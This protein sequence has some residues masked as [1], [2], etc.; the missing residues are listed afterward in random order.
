MC[1]C[2]VL[3]ERWFA[4]SV[5][6]LLLVL[7]KETALAFVVPVLIYIL[8]VQMQGSPCRSC[9]IACIIPLMAMALFFVLQKATT[10]QFITNHYFDS[11]E[12][13]SLNPTHIGVS[14]IK[15]PLGGDRN[16]LWGLCFALQ[17]FLEEGIFTLLIDRW[18]LCNGIFGDLRTPSLSDA[19]LTSFV[20]CCCLQYP[21]AIYQ[22]PISHVGGDLNSI[23]LCHRFQ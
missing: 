11:H 22:G 4:Y 10:G 14:F 16:H 17:R 6:A 19:D 15:V 20:C 21:I 8:W 7:L 2:F 1:I 3:Q 12:L 9:I 5:A 18:L 23:T 13:F